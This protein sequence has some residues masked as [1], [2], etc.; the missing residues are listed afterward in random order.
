MSF[1]PRMTTLIRSACIALAFGLATA[2]AQAQ[3]ASPFANLAGE[4]SGSGTIDLADGGREPIKCRA[5]YDV[6]QQQNN[7][8]LNIRCASDSYN[9][10]LRGSATLAANSVSGSWSEATRNA[11]GSIS[12]TAK[13]EHIDVIAES[14]AFTAGLSLVTHG[15]KQSVVIKPKDANA[16]IR[17]ATIN[18]R[19][20]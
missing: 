6:L 3:S 15:S 8:Q 17:G 2:G 5:A 10:D 13:G 7:L 9:F 16:G 12:G 1:R 18:L 20:S 14:P 19:R 4:W 11:S